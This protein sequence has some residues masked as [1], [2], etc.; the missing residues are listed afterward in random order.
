MYYTYD[1]NRTLYTIEKN[2]KTYKVREES[3]LWR[4]Y[5]KRG[6]RF[7]RL[8]SFSDLRSLEQA[9]RLDGVTI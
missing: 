6:G 1:M 3:M 8:Q 4:I 2:G 5:E 7:E 9:Y